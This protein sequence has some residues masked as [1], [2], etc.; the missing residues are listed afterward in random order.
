MNYIKHLTGFFNH[1]AY[2]KDLRTTHISLYMSL[3]Q[4][5]NIN[6][7]INPISINREDLMKTSKIASTA[8]YHK[9][10][11][12]LQ[13]SG[14][15]EYHP[16]FKPFSGSKIYMRNLTEGSTPKN[17]IPKARISKK[18]QA[19]DQILSEKV[20]KTNLASSNNEQVLDQ[21]LSEKGSKTN[22][23]SSNN[24][25]AIGQKT[26]GT[27]SNFDRT[28]SK[29]DQLND[30]VNDQ[31]Y[32]YNNKTKINKI[33]K[34]NKI[35]IEPENDFLINDSSFQKKEIQFEF[36]K[37]QTETNLQKTENEIPTTETVKEYFLLEKNTEFEA[38][39]FFNYYSS[40]G[41]LIGGKTSMKD[42]K[43]SARNWMLNTS[44]FSANI[45][46]SKSA[47]DQV[48]DQNLYVSSEKDY[49][50]PL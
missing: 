17:D 24:E 3:F 19:L 28:L 1:I 11:N 23:T 43:A 49:A 21:I 18:K 39:R 13:D 40:T 8:T 46:K 33:N 36:Q 48:K 22:L 32:I 20:A 26:N 4:S 34:T 31:L 27:C 45:P 29:N 35:Y 47:N 30:Q 37:K 44:K 42:W 7:F 16:S 9:C 41:W 14:L 38:E 5:W 2:D 50:E 10:I 12:E 6:R 25:Q 15:L